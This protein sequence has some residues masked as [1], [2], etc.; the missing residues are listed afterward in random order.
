M[1]CRRSQ[2]AMRYM[3]A[4]EPT[5]STATATGIRS[6]VAGAPSALMGSYGDDHLVSRNIPSSGI[7]QQDVVDCGPG[8]NTFAADF[9]DVILANCEEGSVSGS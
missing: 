1:L 2:A 3:A 6:S 4:P 9:D 5:D 7:R 8:Y